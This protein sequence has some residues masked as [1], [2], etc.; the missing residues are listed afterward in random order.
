MSDVTYEFPDDDKQEKSKRGRK[1][2]GKEGTSTALIEKA[3]S[4]MERIERLYGDGLPYDRDRLE[5]NVKSQLAQT[6]QALFEAGKIFLRLRAHE[7]LEGYGGFSASLDRIGVA[8]RTAY[9]AMAVVLKFGPVVQ[10]AAQ[11]GS[12]K[13]RM[14]SVFDDEDIQKYV[15]GGPLGNISHD[16]VERM[17]SRELKAALREERKKNKEQKEVQEDAI[18]RK[19]QKISELEQ[20]LRYMDPPT[21]EQKLKA[22]AARELEKRMPDLYEHMFRG[23]YHMDEA[24]KV[25]LQAQGIPGADYTMLQNWA[26]SHWDILGPLNEVL[27]ALE[28]H[29]NHC[30]PERPKDF[31]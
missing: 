4:D 21:E 17:T 22:Q 16:D 2:K 7:E 25:I 8:P 27:A 12:E 29:I 6:A 19:E 28:D 15:E 23:Y 1:P 5:D 26:K 31:A 9:Y 30:H 24:V 13:L 20:Q 10:T 18:A 11:L 14:L 3:V